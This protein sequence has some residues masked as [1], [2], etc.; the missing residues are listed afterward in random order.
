MDR[1]LRIAVSCLLL[2]GSG[3]TQMGG[4]ETSIVGPGALIWAVTTNPSSDQDDPYALILDSGFVYVGGFQT[5]GSFD[6]AWRIEKWNASDSSQG[7]LVSGFGNGGAVFS[8][9]SPGLD[10][11]TGMTILSQSLYVVGIEKGTINN[12]PWRIEKRHLSTGALDSTFGTGG[13]VKPDPS[14]DGLPAITANASGIYIVGS[15]ISAG[16]TGWRI[17]KRK[18]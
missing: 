6:W 13:V 18:K 10:F 11:I 1:A 5:V 4:C 17:E 7:S 15:D 3:A 12:A 8:N 2:V 16:N 9:P 14:T